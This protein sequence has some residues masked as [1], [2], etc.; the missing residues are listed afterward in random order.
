M[1]RAAGAG[2]RLIS[3][4]LGE[5]LALCDRIVVM[6]RGAV[7]GEMLHGEATPET[8]GLLMAGRAA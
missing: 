6:F 1:R 7:I 2:L 4:E 8:L 3:T 5:I